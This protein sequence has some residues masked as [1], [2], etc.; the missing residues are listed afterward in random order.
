[1]NAKI[2]R[3]PSLAALFNKIFRVRSVCVDVDKSGSSKMINPLLSK[4]VRFDLR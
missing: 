2:K 4:K 3:R 1:M